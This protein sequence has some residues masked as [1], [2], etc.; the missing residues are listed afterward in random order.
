[1]ALFLLQKSF[2]NISG[3]VKSPLTTN[4]FPCLH[5]DASWRLGGG[6]RLPGY[7][8]DGAGSQSTVESLGRRLNL[9]A[10]LCCHFGVWGMISAACTPL[11]R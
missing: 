6:S 3:F 9:V 2:G 5:S 11:V 7:G 4:D 10:V 8:T 1:M